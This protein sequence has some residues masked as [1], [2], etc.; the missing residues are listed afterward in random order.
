MSASHLQ[1]SAH[2]YII[3]IK[4]GP[5]MHCSMFDTMQGN[6]LKERV[7]FTKV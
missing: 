6:P 4:R 1:L 7:C 3:S 5:W 2:N